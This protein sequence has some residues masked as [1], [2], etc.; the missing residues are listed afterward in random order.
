MFATSQTF[1]CKIT[2]RANR[3]HDG[4]LSMGRCRFGPLACAHGTTKKL[5]LYFGL[6]GMDQ[7][8]KRH[9]KMINQTIQGKST[10]EARSKQMLKTCRG[11]LFYLEPFQTG[12]VM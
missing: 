4:T 11:V 5:N 7:H 9:R 1:A 12:P 6:L 10:L 8:D 3:R 2:L